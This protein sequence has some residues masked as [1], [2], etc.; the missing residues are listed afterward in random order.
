VTGGQ[1]GEDI[2]YARTVSG[3]AFEPPSGSLTTRSNAMIRWLRRTNA[4]LPHGTP[5]AL[6]QHSGR[7]MLPMHSSGRS[8]VRTGTRWLHG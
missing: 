8:G 2:A 4:D 6:G 7:E 1:P 3:R 5:R